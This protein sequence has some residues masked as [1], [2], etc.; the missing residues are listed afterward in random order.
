MP[1]ETD[2]LYRKLDAMTEDECIA[3]LDPIC[4]VVKGVTEPL[5][6][7]GGRVLPNRIFALA[8]LELYEQWNAEVMSRP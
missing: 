6:G 7:Q 1:I 5:P 8:V 2:D 4:A 3:M